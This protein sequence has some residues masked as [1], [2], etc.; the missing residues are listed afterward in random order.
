MYSTYDVHFYASF[1]LSVLW[2]KLQAVLQR[3]FC[4]TIAREDRHKQWH[5]FR[6]DITFRKKKNSVPHD[7]GDPCEEPFL[8]INSYPIHDVSEWRDLDLKFVLQ[9]YRDYFLSGD[10][11]QL[12]YV[13]KNICVL[14]NGALRWDVDGDGMIENAGEPDQTYDTWTMSGTR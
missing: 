1:A 14:M 2:P 6:G 4:D 10:L 3:D 7:L 13:W 11:S 12:K 5:L 8:K 9:C